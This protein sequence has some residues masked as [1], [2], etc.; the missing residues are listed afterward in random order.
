MAD[1]IIVGDELKKIL[2]FVQK[3]KSR[4]VYLA[5]FVFLII[6]FFLKV[7]VA[8]H[9]ID[10]TTGNYFFV[11]PDSFVIYRYVQYVIDNGSLMVNDAL[12]Y[13]PLGYD[14]RA[15]FGFLAFFLAYTYK[16]FGFAF[17]NLPEFLVYYPVI[18]FIIVGLLRFSL[19]RKLFDTQLA[20]LSVLIFAFDIMTN[21]RFEFG[22]T[23]KEP[24]A[25]IFFYVS[26]IL[27]LLVLMDEKTKSW[28]KYLLSSLSGL[29]VFA[30]GMLWGGVQFLFIFYALLMILKIIFNKLDKDHYICSLILFLSYAIPLM[31]FRA[32]RFP[33]N[34]YYGSPVGM[35]VSFSLLLGAFHIFLVKEEK[36]KFFKP[37]IE[38][39]SPPIF[40]ILFTSLIV[41]FIVLV[42]FGFNYLKERL[43]EFYIELI[44]PLYGTGRWSRTVEEAGLIKLSEFPRATGTLPFLFTLFGLIWWLYDLL[45]NITKEYKQSILVF[46]VFIFIFYGSVW[47]SIPVLKDNP[48]FYLTF[49]LIF[50]FAFI[51]YSSYRAFIKKGETYEKFTSIDLKSLFFIS[52]FIMFSLGFTS[53]NRL[54]FFFSMIFSTFLAYFLIK[55]VLVLR[56]LK[57]LNFRYAGYIFIVFL[58][59]FPTA[60]YF[61]S[62]EGVP[63]LQEGGYLIS[64]VEK[65]YYLDRIYRPEFSEEFQRAMKWIR[66]STP[67]DAVFASWW[68]YGYWIQTLGERATIADGGNSRGAI[69]HFI[70]RYFI[71]AKNESEVMELMYAN[72]VSH[73][74]ISS[75]D[76][77]K[78]LAISGIGSNAN[79]D[80]YSWIGS[81]FLTQK[82]PVDARNFYYTFSG[83]HPFD[84]DTELNGVIFPRKYSYIYA[85]ELPMRFNETGVFEGINQPTV[86]IKKSGSQI[87]EKALV[88]CV[89]MDRLRID[90]TKY[91]I[92]GCLYIVPHFEMI[93]GQL[94]PRNTLMGAFYVPEKI[95]NSFLGRYYFFDEKPEHFEKVYDST[96]NMKEFYIV[97]DRIKGPLVI[98]KINYPKNMKDN[99]VFRG[100][101]LPDESVNVYNKNIEIDL[102]NL[103]L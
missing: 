94:Q 71:T 26:T 30:T 73:V 74:M 89:F 91:D 95:L 66:E 3:H 23:D 16:I 84:E 63:I 98:W 92:D 97:G 102:N 10:T 15:E 49:S 85:V 72:N 77:G 32:D 22:F 61:R 24:L 51:L 75:T 52:M 19:L 100:T 86:R 88:K 93:N 56:K 13:F 64:S 8:H 90:F 33:Y 36:V 54:V 78:Y 69:N 28:K 59:L 12:R 1:E 60:V 6:G 101:E 58:F 7:Q 96:D 43:L 53:V 57:N 42:L 40:T 47:G 41:L 38:K 9:L 27:F 31:I 21:S 55:F 48:R 29:A 62:F 82:T 81:F 11:D 17:S 45:K 76:V 2:P 46:L 99:P 39:L 35:V 70:A 80:R 67:K 34:Y 65:Y 14:P 4:L 68:D 5:V 25:M 87:R 50:L 18:A 103:P 44:D 37:Y 83:Y 79:Y 20:L